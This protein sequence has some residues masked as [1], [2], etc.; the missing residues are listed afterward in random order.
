MTYSSE[1]SLSG[2]DMLY[3]KALSAPYTYYGQTPMIDISFGTLNAVSSIEMEL[4]DADGDCNLMP[5][6]PTMKITIT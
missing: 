4:G 6:E 5:G 2:D 3:T 1:I